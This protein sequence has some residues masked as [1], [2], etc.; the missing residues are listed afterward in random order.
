MV[1][2][3]CSYP[4]SSHPAFIGQVKVPKWLE[5]NWL[6]SLF[7]QSRRSVAKNYLDFVEKVNIAYL[8]NLAKDISDVDLGKYFGNICG[9]AVTARY[10]HVLEQIRQNRRLKGKVN[11]DRNRIVNN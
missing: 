9:A 6:L 2:E 3:P 5:L 11:R 7:G 8:D 4:F 1:T 10:K